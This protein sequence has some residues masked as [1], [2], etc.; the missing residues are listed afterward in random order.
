VTELA[1]RE[2]RDVAVV[3]LD[4]TA[5][6]PELRTLLRE[7]AGLDALEVAGF[8]GPARLPRAFTVEEAAALVTA[9]ERLGVAARTE[10]PAI[11]GE[12]PE[13]SRR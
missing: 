9:L 2:V 10:V 13:P 1:P 3:L 11:G 7:R 6:T 12:W 4:V 8:Y 5:P